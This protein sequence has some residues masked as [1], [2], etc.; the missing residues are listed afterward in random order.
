MPTIRTE[1]SGG[2]QDREFKSRAIRNVIENAQ[3]AVPL[4]L[5]TGP[6]PQRPHSLFLMVT[7][8]PSST[9]LL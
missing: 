9:L 5:L 4:P 3:A 8:V 2:H 7:H 1:P 6:L